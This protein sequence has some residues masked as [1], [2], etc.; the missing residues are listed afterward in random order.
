MVCYYVKWR[1]RGGFLA[2]EN[3]SI[4]V[5]SYSKI[6]RKKGKESKSKGW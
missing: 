3:E 4:S 5:A 2:T 6:F 1:D